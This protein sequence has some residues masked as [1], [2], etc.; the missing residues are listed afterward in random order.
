MRVLILLIIVTFFA[1][2]VF[3]QQSSHL[4]VEELESEA[5]PWSHLNVFDDDD[6]FHFVVVTDRTGGH[7]PGVFPYGISRIN[8]VQPAFVVSV[9]DLIEGYTKDE[10]VLNREWE[11]FNGFIDKLEMPFF[12]VAG[13]HDYTNEVMAEMW[14]ERFGAEYYHFIYKDVLFLCLNSEDGATAL[15][16]PNIEEEQFEYAKKVLADNPDVRWTMV[17]MHQPLWIRPSAKN[18]FKIEGLLE[19]RKHSVF[20]GHMHR[21]S[22]YDRNNSDYFILATMGGGSA[23][24]GKK[25]GEFDHFMWVT[26]TESGPYFANILLDGVEDKS[27]MTAENLSIVRRFDSNPPIKTIPIFVEEPGQMEYTLEFNLENK[28]EEEINYSIEFEPNK[29]LEPEY[30]KLEKMVS[31]KSDDVMSLSMKQRIPLEEITTPL[32]ATTRI[33]ADEYKWDSKVRI[34]P[35]YKHYIEDIPQ[36]VRVDGD[37]TEWGDL[38]YKK[39]SDD[40]QS[41]SFSFDIRKDETYVYVGIDVIDDE[42]VCGF[43]NSAFE[44]DGVFFDFDARP[45]SRSAYNLRTRQA[46]MR[47]QYIFLA[48]A[49]VS[50]KFDLS[51]PEMLPKGVLGKGKLTDKGYSVEYAI[52]TSIL[53]KYQGEAWK[54]MRIN[55]NILDKDEGDKEV[56][57]LNWKPDWSGN[58]PG[59]GTFFRKE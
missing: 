19:G 17:F 58:H 55:V 39:E 37:L 51:F 4:K 7:R 14:K 47:K 59:S 50:Q 31:A 28:Q 16:D 1:L 46:L 3:S 23:L 43:G 35:Y 30:W 13:N 2:P 27:V 49:P 6:R 11:E 48:A 10:E 21:Y 24:R 8:L 15:K 57:Q 33:E 5:K 54:N 44:Q 42:L 9:G 26:M 20:T 22:L 38:K 34:M 18:W 56:L 25:R 36:K 32:L 41:S 40:P 52:P 53:D 29:S 45:I 12:Y